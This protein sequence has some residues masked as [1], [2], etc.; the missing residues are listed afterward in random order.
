MKK[1]G[2]VPDPVYSFPKLS[3]RQQTLLAIQ[4]SKSDGYAP[5]SPKSI[6]LDT[7]ELISALEDETRRVRLM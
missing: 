2:A 4:L 1:T 3:L 6:D 5:H 7:K